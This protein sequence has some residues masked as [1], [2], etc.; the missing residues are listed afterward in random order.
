MDVK[1]AAQVIRDSVSMDQIMSLYG[2][3][4]KHGFMVCPFHG[5]KDPSMKIYNGKNGHSG[6]HC[7]GCGRG[8]SVIDFVQE[9]ENCD[10]RTAVRAIDNACRL[11]LFP[12]DEDPYQLE[13]NRQIQQWLDDFADAMYAYLDAVRMKVEHEIRTDLVMVKELEMLRQMEPPQLTAAEYDV[14]SQWKEK[15]EYN[16]YKLEKISE[17]REEVAAWRRK[18]RKAGS[19]SSRMK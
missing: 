3:T 8:G 7:F 4:A 19:A 17:L 18:A 12:A 10:F 6:W 9:H 11:G 1:S 13:E 14:I 15:S 5:D 2:Y 16:E